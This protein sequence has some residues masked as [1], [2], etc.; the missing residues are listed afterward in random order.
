VKLVTVG[1]VRSRTV[2]TLEKVKELNAFGCENGDAYALKSGEASVPTIQ[3]TRVPQWYE[4]ITYDDL[5][6]RRMKPWTFGLSIVCKQTIF[7]RHLPHGE[8]PVGV[9]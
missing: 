3:N 8:Q 2:R 1:G 5:I 7:R 9:S 6:P 4:A